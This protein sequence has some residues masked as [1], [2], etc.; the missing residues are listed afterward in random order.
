MGWPDVRRC[1]PG[2]DAPGHLSAWCKEQ[3]GVDSTRFVSIGPDGWRARTH[4][5][6][7]CRGSAKEVLQDPSAARRAASFPAGKNRTATVFDGGGQL[8]GAGAG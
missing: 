3:L 8:P 4:L 2:L 6:V 1:A 7:R 5:S